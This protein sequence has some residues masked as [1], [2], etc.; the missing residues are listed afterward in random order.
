MKLFSKNYLI[1]IAVLIGMFAYFS[2]LSSY[3][4]QTY[5]IA[6]IALIF[7]LAIGSF[8]NVLIYRLP[9]ML[10]NQWQKDCAEF[11]GQS[12]PE[13]PI[14]NLTR[15]ASACPHCQSLVQA[16]QNIP[17]ISFLILRGKCA[18]CHNKISWQYVSVETLTG[19]FFMLLALKLGLSYSFAAYVVLISL[20][21]ALAVIDLNS[22]LLPDVITLPLI[23]LGLL[24]NYFD[25]IVDLETAFLGT[26]LGYLILYV[27]ANL[28]FWITKREGMGAGD[29]KLLAALGAWLGWHQLPLIIFL[30]AGCSAL[31]GLILIWRNKM[32]WQTP[33]AF[34]PYLVGAAGVSIFLDDYLPIWHWI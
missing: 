31:V 23:W 16:W 1:V 9:I 7:G 20:L 6:G 12:I 4:S 21:I 3:A 17:I 19:L 24:V 26:L 14:F 5:Q 10:E 18:N 15:P 22:H 33:Q 28:F 32:T 29:F 30:S 13:K 11:L 27:V 2:I 8:L 25:V 34:G